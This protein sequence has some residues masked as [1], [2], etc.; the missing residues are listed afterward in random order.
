ME[1]QAQNDLIKLKIFLVIYT[2]TNKFW[3]HDLILHP[4]L[5]EEE[6]P[7]WAK[8]HSQRNKIM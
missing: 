7:I 3:T 8:A 5:W 2:Y 1:E 6:V 4:F